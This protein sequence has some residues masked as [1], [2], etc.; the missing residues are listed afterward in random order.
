M[1]N[2]PANK[3]KWY[4]SKTI[5]FNVF[6]AALG[7]V[8]EITGKMENGQALTFIAVINIILRTVTKSAIIWK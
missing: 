6:L 4:K 8:M 2:N 3:K 5:W 7:I 1:P